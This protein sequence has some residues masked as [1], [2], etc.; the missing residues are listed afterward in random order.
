MVDKA[1]ANPLYEL[2]GKQLADYRVHVKE[3][4]KGAFAGVF[5]FS[6]H[7]NGH[8]MVSGLYYIGSTYIRPWLEIDYSPITGDEQDPTGESLFKLLSELI[9]PGGHISVSYLD[10]KITARALLSGVPPAATPIGYLLWIG[11]CRWFKDWY[12]AEGWKE[13]G[14]KLQGEKPLHAE[15]E[16]ENTAKI[17]EELKEFLGKAGYLEP[18]MENVC[19]ELARKVLKIESSS[20]P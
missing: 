18:E 5:S 1:K 14:I 2:D 12:F 17:T 16:K 3:V 15:R 8:E 10:H 7:V 4:K 6:L 20:S 19:K 13:G 11:G 9:P